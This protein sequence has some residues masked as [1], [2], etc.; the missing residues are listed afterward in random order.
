MGIAA[1]LTGI[2][3]GLCTVY[4]AL[5]AFDVLPASASLT[6][7]DWVFWLMAAAVLL[8]GTIALLMGRS[9]DVE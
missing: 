4:G 2:L 1:L 9:H 5:D 6:R 8:L 7:V 3:G